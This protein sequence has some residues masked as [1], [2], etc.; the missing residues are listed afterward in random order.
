[1]LSPCICE[2]VE[3]N[4]SE[5]VCQVNKSLHPSYWITIYI[6][7]DLASSNIL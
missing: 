6:M 4:D 7:S 3:R 2:I 1:M 5:Q